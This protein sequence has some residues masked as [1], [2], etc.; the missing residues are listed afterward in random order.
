MTNVRNLKQA[1][2][3]GLIETADYVRKNPA[4]FFFYIDYTLE[5]LPSYHEILQETV[6]E[7]VDYVLIL[8]SAGEIPNQSQS[9]NGLVFLLGTQHFHNDLRNINIVKYGLACLVR[10]VCDFH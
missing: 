10:I 9:H 2:C 3:H 8:L 7:N 5:L 1:S 6:F 4:Y